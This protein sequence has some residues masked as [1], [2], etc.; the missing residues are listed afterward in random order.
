M[1][2]RNYSRRIFDTPSRL[3]QGDTL[4]PFLFVLVHDWVLR[5][6]LPSDD[7]S[8]LLQRRESRRHQSEKR[9]SVLGDAD[10]RTLLSS[11]FEGAKRLTL[12]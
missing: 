2:F 11:T 12:Q 4:A 10:D 9:L 3:L 6:A 7:D 5:T 8:F 1:A